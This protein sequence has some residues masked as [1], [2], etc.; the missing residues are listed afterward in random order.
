MKGESSR[1]DDSK[2]ISP[3]GS[4]KSNNLTLEYLR[5]ITNNFS[6]ER[7]LGEGGFGKVYK[8]VLENGEMIA[9]KKITSPIPGIMDKQF[10]NEAYHLMRLKHRNIVL[11]VG[12]C[13]E[14]EST[15]L[16]YNGKYIW[17][18]KSERLLCLEYMPKGSLRQYLSDESSG[19]NWDTRYKVIEGICYGLHYLHEEWQL[20]APIIHLDLKPANILLD[21]NM[22][23][24]IA[25][26]GLSRLFSEEKTWTCTTSRDGSLGYMAPEYINRG[27]ITKKADI[28][29]LGVIIIEIITGHKD[30]PDETGTSSKEYIELILDK[31]RSRLKQSL[32]YTSTK[33][34]I[35]CQQIRRCIHIG[36]ICVKLDRSKRPTT[37]EIIKMFHGSEGAEGRRRK[38]GLGREDTLDG[39]EVGEAPNSG[40]PSSPRD[41]K[42]EEEDPLPGI[43]GL[44]VTGVAF[45]GKE[46]QAS[47]YPING[48]V[49]CNFQ[50]LRH[51]GDGSINYIEGAYFSSYLITANDVDT[52]L[53]V[54]VQPIDSKNR[55]G[56]VYKVYCNE[57]RKIT[58]DPETTEHI[59][60]TLEIG[61]V[62]YE[63]K[64]QLAHARYLDMWEPA[65]QM[66][67]RDGYT[68]KRNGQHG[69]MITEKFQEATI[70]G[71][72]DG[73]PTEFSVSSANGAQHNLKPAENTLPRDT[74]V[75]VMR[76]FRLMALERKRE[77]LKGL[78]SRF[79]K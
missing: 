41:S 33:I 71:I 7:L 5:K 53:A 37:S 54:E 55:K 61:H 31:W 6:D 49:T 63:V 40:A 23:P 45:P 13:S 4:S 43:D 14:T 68:I 38:E 78:L 32:D 42:D 58:C 77:G 60:K 25:D 36:L 67:K 59:K 20:N 76:L 35:D 1:Q 3:D 18:E 2:E 51:L 57:E 34:R 48:T 21:N 26:F 64:V 79:F 73:R 72:P 28:F 22:A 65:V 47:G 75:L 11:L 12:C 9:V 69:V 10:E 27:L 62:I 74:I 30:Y 17:A 29:S 8:G 15:Y 44:S 24:K 52:L 46:L 19:L 56:E 70:I 39:S 16:E 66:T 50:W